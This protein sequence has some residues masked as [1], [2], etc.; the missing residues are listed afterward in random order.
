MRQR[1]ISGCMGFSLSYFITGNSCFMFSFLFTIIILYTFM[2][3]LA[4]CAFAFCVSVGFEEFVKKECDLIVDK[5][6]VEYNIWTNEITIRRDLIA[7]FSTSKDKI[8]YA[9]RRV[10]TT[11]FFWDL[12]FHIYP[13]KIKFV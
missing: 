1:L 3:F 8:E 5:I 11:Y 13:L 10:C 4:R 9:F 12:Y 2:V 7:S 6:S